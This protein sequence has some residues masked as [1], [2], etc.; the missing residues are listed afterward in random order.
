MISESSGEINLSKEPKL[1]F[2][3][4]FWFVTYADNSS[5][6]IETIND[7]HIENIDHIKDQISKKN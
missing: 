6:I 2:S 3:K 4:E 7:R 5:P 1:P